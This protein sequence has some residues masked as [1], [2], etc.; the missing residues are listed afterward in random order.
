M[1]INYRAEVIGSLLRPGY[2][3]Q[4]R[5]QWENHEI[6]TREFKEI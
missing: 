6:S 5:K 1:A 3:K 2:L 4:A